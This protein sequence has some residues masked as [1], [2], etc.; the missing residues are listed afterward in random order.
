MNTCTSEF[1]YVHVLSFS[2]QHTDKQPLIYVVFFFPLYRFVQRLLFFYKPS[3]NLYG[4]LELEHPKA[5][6][7]TVVGCQYI[8][9]LLASE[10]VRTN[11]CPQLEALLYT[12]LH[13]LQVISVVLQMRLLDY[14]RFGLETTQLKQGDFFAVWVW[15]NVA[16]FIALI[17][18]HVSV[19]ALGM[20]MTVSWSVH[21]FGPDWNISTT[22]EWK[23]QSISPYFGLWLNTYKTCYIPISLSC[24]YHFSACYHVFWVTTPAE[25]NTICH[26]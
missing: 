18:S 20:E 1:S 26:R 13:S 17:F 7:L 5:R 21:H 25:E 3:S 9:F 2:F 12:Y 4:S 6:Q 24:P 22:I 8:E 14:L 10:E 11:S 23:C 16:L 19:M 15:H